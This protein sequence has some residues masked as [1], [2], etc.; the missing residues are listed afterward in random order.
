MARPPPGTNR[1]LARPN[2]P[3]LRCLAR[4]ASNLQRPR[5]GEE[6]LE[7]ASTCEYLGEPQGRGRS[8]RYVEDT[9]AWRVPP[10]G[11][12]SHTKLALRWRI[13]PVESVLHLSLHHVLER[14]VRA[15]DHWAAGL[16]AASLMRRPTGAV[17]KRGRN[18]TE[19]MRWPAA[20]RVRHQDLTAPSDQELTHVQ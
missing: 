5:R 19:W 17:T 15:P 4:E 13:G 10:G 9:A 6:G 11:R 3:G 12:R 20:A 1:R 7:Q 18:R 8:L 14:G 2:A 16:Q